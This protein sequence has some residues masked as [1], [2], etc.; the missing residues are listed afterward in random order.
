MLGIH[1]KPVKLNVYFYNRKK[2]KMYNVILYRI[3][4]FGTKHINHEFEFATT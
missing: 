3:G 2:I 4:L 1:N